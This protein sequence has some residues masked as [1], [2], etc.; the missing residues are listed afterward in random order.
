M[1]LE[2]VAKGKPLLLYQYM[3]NNDNKVLKR[4]SV[5]Y[6]KYVHNNY[7]AVYAVITILVMQG[8]IQDYYF[9]GERKKRSRKVTHANT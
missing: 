5:Q 1:M 8:F 9:V 4:T 7:S 6:H 3:H 2:L